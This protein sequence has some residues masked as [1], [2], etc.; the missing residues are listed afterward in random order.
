[1]YPATGRGQLIPERAATD[2]VTNAARTRSDGDRTR[3][4]GRRRRG[5]TSSRRPGRWLE[6][7]T[8][9]P[10]ARSRRRAAAPARRSCGPACR[11]SLGD[12][13]AWAPAAIPEWSAIHPACRP[14]TS[15]T[16]HR[17]WDSAVVRM[18]PTRAA[19]ETR[20]LAR[21]RERRVSPRLAPSWRASSAD[22]AC[23][24]P[25][26]QQMLG[27]GSGQTSQAAAP[28]GARSG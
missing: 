20:R 8:L 25:A 23:G 3:G 18:R 26:L 11:W 15:S 24:P 4:R 16:M 9:P 21:R 6:G 13:D 5:T 22:A 19:G 27:H 14:I 1:M 10:A 17:W 7:G 28:R 12:E 2:Y